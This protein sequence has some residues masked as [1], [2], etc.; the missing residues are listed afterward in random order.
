MCSTATVS[1]RSLR[2]QVLLAL[3]C[4][5]AA[6]WL[7]PPAR[8]FAEGSRDMFGPTNGGSRANIEWRT[9]LYGDLIPRRTLFHVF[10]RA[11]E[12]IV[13]GSSAVGAGGSPDLGDILAYAPE[14]FSGVNTGA[15]LAG[16][17]AFSCRAQRAS[18]GNAGRGRIATRAEELAGPLPAPGGYSPCFYA[19]P[20]AGLYTIVFYGPEGDGSD[21]QLLPSGRIEAIAEDFGPLQSTS[22]T[23]WD[24]SVRTRLDAAD[25]LRGRVFSYSVAMFTGGNGRP[26]AS[27]AYIPTFD[28]FVYQVDYSGDPNGFVVYAN[29]YGFQDSDGTPLYHDVLAVDTLSFDE[30]NQLVQLQGGVTLALPEYPL[31]LS[32]PDPLVLEAL[33]IPLSP[34]PPQISDLLFTGVIT[35]NLTLVDRGGAFTFTSSGPGVYTLIISR[36]GSSFEPDSL[37]NRTLIGL[38]AGAGPTRVQWDGRDNAGLPFPEGASYLARIVVQGG[39]VHFPFLDVENNLE[40]GPT[41]TLLNA[42]DGVCP[43][44]EGGCFA[45]FYDDQGYLTANGTLVGTAVDGPLC[46]NNSGRPP[47]PSASD[48]LRGYDTRGRQ[49]GFGF[50]TDGNPETICQ[51]QGGFGD[52]KGLDIWTYYPSNVVLTPIRIVAPT[53][54]RLNSFDAVAGPA[55]TLVRWETGFEQGTLGFHLYRSDDHTWAGARRITTRPIVARGVAGGGAAYRWLDAEAVAGQAAWYWLQELTSD[56]SAVRA[57]P[58]LRAAAPTAAPL[59]HLLPLVVIERGAGAPV[60]ELLGGRAQS[61]LEEGIPPW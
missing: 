24:I 61:Y 13:L 15:P 36:D 1:Y 28:G 11:G 43:P 40:G 31:F 21:I 7:A 34:Q 16:P 17:P 8:L 35:T 38:L 52:K 6:A 55:G 25:E 20:R 30:Q 37:Q 60:R 14:L 49:R 3:I 23:A 9:S 56:G 10:A 27:T 47:T 41:I 45:A 12:V 39:E 4:L 29:H 57:G 5:L 26:V 46:A 22:V 53:A 19:A 18:P 59:R 33:G 2:R 42:P 48:P 44:L 54:V 50:A 51:E 32:P 58:A